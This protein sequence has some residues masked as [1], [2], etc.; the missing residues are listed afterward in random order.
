M[1]IK[2]KETYINNIITII[3][4]VGMIMFGIL[5]NMFKKEE[6]PCM[7]RDVVTALESAVSDMDDQVVDRAANLRNHLRRCNANLSNE[8]KVRIVRALNTAKVRALMDGTTESFS[9]FR[10]LDS[11]S[12]DVVTLL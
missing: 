5:T 4:L 7:R 6:R 8:E 2:S 10:L 9:T 3:Y 12:S 1:H 11:I